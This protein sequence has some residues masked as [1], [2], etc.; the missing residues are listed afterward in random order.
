MTPGAEDF[1]ESETDADEMCNFEIDL[2][3][4]LLQVEEYTR[5]LVPAFSPGTD[6]DLV[7]KRVQLRMARQQRLLDGSLRLWAVIG[8]PALDCPVG[9]VD[10]QRKQLQRLLHTAEH[11]NV[12]LQVLP[13]GFGEHIA[14]GMPFSLAQY[15]DGGGA[16]VLD[17]LSGILC[18]EDQADLN[19]YSL[20]F[21]HLCAAALPARDSMAL[22]RRK[23]DE[24]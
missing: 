10:V 11:P 5:A 13:Y 16:A 20:A 21:R 18:L 7:T 3:P 8:T 4:G 23:Y 24:L 15:A 1:I 6:E 12:T 19:R 2:I 14:M 22:V 17:L 9:G